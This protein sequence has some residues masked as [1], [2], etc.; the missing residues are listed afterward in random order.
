MLSSTS[1]EAPHQKNKSCDGASRL[2][3]STIL[4][5]AVVL[6]AIESVKWS[7]LCFVCGYSI[8]QNKPNLYY[9]CL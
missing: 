2:D 7:I 3:C 6:W 4:Q 9:T 8:D 1:E 5:A